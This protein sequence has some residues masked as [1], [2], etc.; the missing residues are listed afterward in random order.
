[1]QFRRLLTAEEKTS[2]LKRFGKENDNE[3]QT[4]YRTDDGGV[5]CDPVRKAWVQSHPQSYP[6]NYRF[7]SGGATPKLKIMEEIA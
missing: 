2:C 7:R 6:E 4:E 1:M 3:R 5:V